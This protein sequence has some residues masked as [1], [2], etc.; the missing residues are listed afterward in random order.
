[1]IYLRQKE[2]LVAASKQLEELRQRS[3]NYSIGFGT[4]EGEAILEDL[5]AHCGVEK[6]GYTRGATNQDDLI[7]VEGQREVYQY[8]KYMMRLNSDGRFIRDLVDSMDIEED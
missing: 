1:M 4:K 3:L 8:I 7:F 5:R 2:D 6:C